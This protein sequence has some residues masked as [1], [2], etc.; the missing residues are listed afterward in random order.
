MFTK[1]LQRKNQISRHALGAIRPNARRAKRYHRLASG[2]ATPEEMNA[3]FGAA[4][5]AL[6]MK[7]CP[8]VQHT[9]RKDA[10]VDHIDAAKA[11]ITL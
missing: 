7:N 4:T 6:A 11:T 10:S 9:R 1:D 3:I 5:P 8:E 2:A